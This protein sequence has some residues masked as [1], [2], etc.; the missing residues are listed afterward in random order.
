MI[1]ALSADTLYRRVAQLEQVLRPQE[2][3]LDVLRKLGYFTDFPVPE[4]GKLVISGAAQAGA[5][6]MVEYE[7]WEP[8][9]VKE[10][11][12]NGP[13]SDEYLY[14][15]YG[16][17]GGSISSAGD[18]V[19]NTSQSPAEFP[20]F[21]FGAEVPAKVEM[22]LL[23]ILA[24]DFAPKENDGT[25]YSYTKYLKLIKEREVLFDEDRNGLLLYAPF[26]T[27]YGHCDM[28]G[29][30]ISVIGNASDVDGKYPFVLPKP[31]TFTPG[32]ELLVYHTLEAGGAGQALD[33]SEHE[34]GFVMKVKKVS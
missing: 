9:D 10:T 29:E 33:T 18:H 17:A 26:P 25:D 23:A 14:I 21:P 5:I 8:G 3:I 15:N 16:N 30:G 11:D 2:T 12:P 28:V 31:M 7:V 1:G 34:V 13:K 20:A 4:G 27:S 6:Q 19:L 24:S 32:E 22:T